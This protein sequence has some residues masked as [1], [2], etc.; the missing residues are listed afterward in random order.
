[1][2]ATG[3][4]F[5]PRDMPTVRTI[6]REAEEQDHR[7]SAYVMGI[8][9]STPFQYRRADTVLGVTTDRREVGQ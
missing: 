7:F 4:V 9:T 6:V 8:V 1:M 3:R 5:Q 2:Y